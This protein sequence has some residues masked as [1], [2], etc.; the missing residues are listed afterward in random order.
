MK[1]LSTKLFI[2]LFTIFSVFISCSNN[3]DEPTGTS[4]E[5]YSIVNNVN[6]SYIFNGEGLSNESNPDFTFK[7]GSTYIFNLDT[8]GHPFFIKSVQGS[9]TA[10]A[11]NSGVSNNGAISGS[12]IFTI[13]LDAPNTLYYNCEFH[14]TMTGTFTIID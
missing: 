12:V 8:P 3:D 14:S 2:L 13:P 11:Y 9:T 10:N 7:R 5:I 6:I 1:Y 4:T